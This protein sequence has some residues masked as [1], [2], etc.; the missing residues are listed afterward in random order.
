MILEL[1]GN[2]C[3]AVRQANGPCQTVSHNFFCISGF[4]YFPVITPKSTFLTPFCAQCYIINMPQDAE[5][6]VTAA[7][8]TTIPEIIRNKMR[9]EKGDRLRWKV[10]NGQIIAEKLVP[11][12]PAAAKGSLKHLYQ[13]KSAEAEKSA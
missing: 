6:S 9:L 11:R 12:V 13:A 2:P 8:Q 10:H 5:S 7:W 1:A 4:N 3:A